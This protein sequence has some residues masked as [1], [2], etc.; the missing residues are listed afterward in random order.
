MRYLTERQ[1]IRLA[2]EAAQ[3]T[4][5]SVELMMKVLKAQKSQL[6]WLVHPIALDRIIT[7]ITYPEGAITDAELASLL[8]NAGDAMA[9][10]KYSIAAHC[11]EQ[12]LD[13]L[14]SADRLFG[15]K[16]TSG[17]GRAA[18]IEAGMRGR[19]R[20]FGPDDRAS[21]SQAMVS[22]ASA[23]DLLT[24]QVAPEGSSEARARELI[25][26]GQRHLWEL[27]RLLDAGPYFRPP[28]SN[29]GDRKE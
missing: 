29:G 23:A 5:T 3:R 7:R 24:D 10:W 4:G 12:V 19:A 21:L 16:R 27:R 18:R 2:K 22:F 26:K 9:S 13:E 1:A 17:P 6:E 28:R 15:G 8:R 25:A 14:A 20:L 11:L